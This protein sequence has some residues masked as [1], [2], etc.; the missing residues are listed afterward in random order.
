VP[1]VFQFIQEA[2]QVEDEE[3]RRVFNMGL[4]YLMVVAEGLED[5]ALS[6]IEKSGCRSYRVGE[7][8]GGPHQVRFVG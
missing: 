1:P 7:V 6:M 5:E 3:M 2:G 4:G 8:T